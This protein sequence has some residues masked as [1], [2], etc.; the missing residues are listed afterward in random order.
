MIQMCLR[1]HLGSYGSQNS[2]NVE[3]SGQKVQFSTFNRLIGSILIQSMIKPDL[4]Y[5]FF[6]N[7]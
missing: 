7:S 1:S 5:W 6:V 4:E 3:K 2:W